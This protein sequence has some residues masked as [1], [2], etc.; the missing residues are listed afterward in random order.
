MGNKQKIEKLQKDIDELLSAI[1]M[2]RSVRG[3]N[4]TEDTEK[5]LQKESDRAEKMINEL[6]RLQKQEERG[7]VKMAKEMKMEKRSVTGFE[8]ELRTL[9]TTANGTA[10]IPENVQN[11]IIKKMEEVSPAFKQARKLPSNNG[12]LKVAKENDAVSGGFFGEGEDILEEAINFT[13]VE[14]KQKRLGAAAS[15][16][17]QLI[18]DS[19]VDIVSYVNDLLGRRVAK[20]AEQAIFKGDGA[21]EFSGI[22][23]ETAV[24]ETEY[25]L[26]TE[27]DMD[28]F[29]DVY[30]SLHPTFLDGAAFYMSRSFFNKAV[31]LKDAM[32]HYY[33]QNAVVNGKPTYTLFNRPVFVTEALDAGDTVGQVPVVFANLGQAYSILVKQEMNLRQIIDGQQALR[34]S[35]LLVLDGYMDGAVT[36]H[37]AIAKLTVTA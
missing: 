33:M 10:V 18:N 21:N 5:R 7:N 20:V 35:Q 36:N 9:S 28:S 30:T 12:S 27:L 6:E 16:S 17:N 29:M 4:L 13:N 26:A 1:E 32:G 19:A 8:T 22:M 34:G 2:V 24:N 11:E 15:L 14:L 3:Y 23:L 25:S 37:A 31:K